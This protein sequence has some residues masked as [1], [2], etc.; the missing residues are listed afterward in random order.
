MQI[1]INA[2]F[3]LMRFVIIKFTGGSMPKIILLSMF[4]L[5]S[6]A[7]EAAPV[8]VLGTAENYCVTFCYIKIPYTITGLESTHK[9][10]RIFCDIEAEISS[11][12][13]VYKGETRVRLMQSSPIGA[14][15]IT[16]GPIQ[17]FA[18]MDTGIRKIYFVGSH[19]RTARCHL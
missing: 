13:P 3:W 11:Q 19:V 1:R 8:I 7:A 6:G 14:F 2:I 5:M 10:G 9:I 4:L 15:K 12:L 16:P 17:G 18:E